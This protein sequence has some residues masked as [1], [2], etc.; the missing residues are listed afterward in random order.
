M[1]RQ[2]IALRTP[3]LAYA[4]RAL[5]ILL[6][7]ILIW[8]GA[9]LVLLAAKLSPHTVN[10]ISGYLTLYRDAAGLTLSDFTDTVRVIAGAGGLLVF[11][12]LVYL[13]LQELPRGHLAR[14]DLYLGHGRGGE[15]TVAPRAVERI[16]EIAAGG[17]REV[18]EVSA[19]VGEGA[20]AVHMS[21]R[22]AAS[23]PRALREVRERILEQLSAH[24]LPAL[25]VDVTLTGFH[26]TTR[27]DLS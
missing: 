9:M 16:A 15:L 19:R 25:T 12:L 23:A 17:H 5:T 3:V 21:V 14:G 18:D 20:V 7:L 8:Y 4:V 24:G 10:S 6:A 26:P 22:R 11:S 27:R 1:I 13:A 2:R